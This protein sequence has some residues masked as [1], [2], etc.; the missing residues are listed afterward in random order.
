MGWI[1]IGLAIIL[2]LYIQIQTMWITYVWT[3]WKYLAL[4]NKPILS[5][6]FMCVSLLNKMSLPKYLLIAD[7]AFFLLDTPNYDVL[8]MFILNGAL[9]CNIKSDFEI[10]KI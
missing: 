8:S 5:V 1:Q 2:V 3:K 4:I 6:G 10:N 7:Y 9:T